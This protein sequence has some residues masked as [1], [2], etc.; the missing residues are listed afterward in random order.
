MAIGTLSPC[1]LLLSMVGIAT[2]AASMFSQLRLTPYGKMVLRVL[3]VLAIGMAFMF[4]A[5]D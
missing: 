2:V 5:S 1:T 4:A 3:G